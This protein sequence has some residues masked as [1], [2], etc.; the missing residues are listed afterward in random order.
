MACSPKTN[1]IDL[2]FVPIHLLLCLIN[3]F[4][5][6]SKKSKFRLFTF[7]IEA[8]DTSVM[9]VIMTSSDIAEP[10]MGTLTQLGLI[11]CQ[12]NHGVT[13]KGFI[14][15]YWKKILR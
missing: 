1:I 6:F 5:S 15:F 4:N 3:F 13:V 8:D 12:M 10:C 7:I 9:A 11:A 14:F 2:N